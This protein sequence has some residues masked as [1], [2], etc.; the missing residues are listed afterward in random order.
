MCLLDITQ[1]A[2]AVGLARD[3]RHLRN[4]RFR[5]G[6]QQL[7]AVPDDAAVFL[8][9]PGRN[10]G[11]SSKVTSGMLKA[12]QKRTNRAAFTDASMSSVPARC[13]G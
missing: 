13:A 9:V 11:T 2:P 8:P 10:P 12:S 1:Y 6:E 3:D 7:R 4:R 5:E